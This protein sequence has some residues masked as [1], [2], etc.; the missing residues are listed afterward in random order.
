MNKEKI[1]VVEDDVEIARVVIGHLQREGYDAVWASTG[2][3]GL[4]EFKLQMFDLILVDLM[5][6]QLNGFEF[7]QRI[8][9]ESDVPLCIVS[10]RIEEEN[11]IKGLKLG[12]DDY[13]T[14]PFSLA[15]LTARIDSH[16]RR[17][18]RFLQKEAKEQ[19]IQYQNGLTIDFQK[20]AVYLGDSLLSLTK[21]EQSLLLWLASYPNE[22]FSKK[23][24][25]EYIWN[26][27]DVETN[28]TVTVHI[29]SLRL[30]LNEHPK[31]PS[32]IQTIWG[33]G[34]RFIGEEL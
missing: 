6:P 21:C 13:I 17:Y 20:K 34:Y 12:A 9:Q 5:L 2:R 11:K 16:L 23:E 15:E 28:N 25:Y 27:E 7:C 31:K 1:L 32:F 10:A 4:D 33:T 24:L 29:K 14:K 19:I 26:E 8:R 18:R 22:T 3:E 30:K